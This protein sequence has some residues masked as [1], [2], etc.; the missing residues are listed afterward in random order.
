[1]V[2]RNIVLFVA[3]LSSLACQRQDTKETQQPNLEK[4]SVVDSPP[5]PV[6][7]D[8]MIEAEREAQQVIA[9]AENEFGFFY[10]ERLGR[11]DL[12]PGEWVEENGSKI[13][14]GFLT[15]FEDEDFCAAAIPAD[16]DPFEFNGHTYYMQPLSE[17]S[18]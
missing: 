2:M 1:M 4:P 16:W 11:L 15:R 18:K 7:T 10:Q 8:Q 12:R 6:V 17:T 13:C 3:L 5:V 9:D 14:M